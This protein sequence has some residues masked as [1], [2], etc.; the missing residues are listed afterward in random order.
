[1]SCDMCG[2]HVGQIVDLVSD[3]TCDKCFHPISYKGDA[4][5]LGFQ[6]DLHI[7]RVHHSFRCSGCNDL[8]KFIAASCSGNY[9][10]EF[11]Q[12]IS[13]LFFTKVSERKD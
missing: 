10:E 7:F 4:T 9:S 2:L 6:G 3:G 5:Y 8:K 1:M 12:E 13:K 11:E